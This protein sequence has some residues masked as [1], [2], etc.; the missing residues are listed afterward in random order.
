MKPNQVND[1][2]VNIFLGK[3]FIEK[4]SSYGLIF[5]SHP[6][7]KINITYDPKGRQSV[8]IIH[9]AFEDVELYSGNSIREVSAKLDYYLE[10]FLHDVKRKGNAKNSTNQ[11]FALG[12][13][14]PLSED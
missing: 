6:Q 12:G 3:G 13:T 14:T 5:F 4:R 11:K 10:K 2:Y 1:T 7:A 8:V 9:D